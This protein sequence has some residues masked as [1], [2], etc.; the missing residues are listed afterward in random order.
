MVVA[1]LLPIT[2]IALVLTEPPEVKGFFN[3]V[4]SFASNL[5]SNGYKICLLMYYNATLLAI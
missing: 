1:G 3:L 4:L 5:Y 2:I